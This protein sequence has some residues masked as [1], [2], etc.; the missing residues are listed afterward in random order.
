MKKLSKTYS[1]EQP[2][3]RKTPVTNTAL[4]GEA[5]TQSDDVKRLDWLK[6]ER[7]LAIVGGADISSYIPCDVS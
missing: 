5:G 4:L 1:L 6:A 7:E 2:G 3:K